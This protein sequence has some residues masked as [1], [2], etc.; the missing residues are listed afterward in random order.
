[1]GTAVNNLHRRGQ[2]SFPNCFH[3]QE[4]WLLLPC[5]H[6]PALKGSSPS[7]I[8][9]SMMIPQPHWGSPAHQ[10]LEIQEKEM[11]SLQ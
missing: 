5:C 11:I 4:S 6:T 1:M 2:G 9:F 10:E 8:P 7:L 3:L